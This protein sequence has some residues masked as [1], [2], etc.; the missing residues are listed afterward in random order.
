MGGMLAKVSTLLMSVGRFPQA[1]LGRIGRALARLAALA[2][3]RRDERRLFAAHKGAR[4]DPDVD[5]ELKAAFENSVAQQMLALGLFDRG[6]QALDREAILAADVNVAL[7]R[8][9]GEAGDRHA[10]EHA[11]RIAFEHAPIHERARVALVRVADH[12]LDLR[13]LFHHQLPFEAGRVACA[14]PAAKA[15][16]L[17]LRHYLAGRHGGDRFAERL[18]A[19]RGDV[20]GQL[21]RVDASAVG[22]HDPHLL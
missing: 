7:L 15:A 12:V 9:D 5:A 21:L 18:I 8:A 22:E 4:A 10:F 11:V 19:A 20:V 14:A 17:H 2:F 1:A 16:L 6:L 3:D 13:D